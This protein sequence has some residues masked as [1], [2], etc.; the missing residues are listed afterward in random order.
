MG[1]C[2]GESFDFSTLRET[3]QRINLDLG[4]CLAWLDLGQGL[5]NQGFKTRYMDIEPQPKAGPSKPSAELKP[6]AS[7]SKPKSILI[8]HPPSVLQ[9]TRDIKGKA[10]LGSGVTRADGPPQPPREAYA[11]VVEFVL[12]S[13]ID[14]SSEALWLPCRVE[15][16]KPRSADLAGDA[17]DPSGLSDVADGN[18][19]KAARMAVLPQPLAQPLV[20]LLVDRCC[21]PCGVEAYSGVVGSLEDPGGGVEA[22]GCLGIVV[23]KIRAFGCWFA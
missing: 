8:K 21:N 16:S 17:M 20:S 15:G 1:R 11:G 12:G 3:L 4:C 9:A 6:S 13:V 10:P 7:Q 2:F 18:V 19:L 23:N 5:G 14:P 22:S